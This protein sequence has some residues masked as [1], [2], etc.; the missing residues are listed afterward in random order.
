MRS[1]VLWAA[2]LLCA[3]GASVAGQDE[4]P[5][6]IR[7][8]AFVKTNRT[9]FE[10]FG[11]D[12]GTLDALG[13]IKWKTEEWNALFAVYAGKDAKNP[14]V[15]GEY[16]VADGGLLFEPRQPLQGG[17]R[18]RAEFDPAKLPD[19]RG[20]GKERI[21]R[22]FEIPSPVGVSASG[23]GGA[24]IGGPTAVR[25][26]YP[27]RDTLPE[28]QLKFYI[29]FT[30]PMGR[31]SA[32]KHVRLL[33]AKDKEI[34][35]PFLE[36]GEE[37]WDEQ[38][39][40]FT[41]FFDPGRIKRG[42]KPREEVGPALEEGKSY[43]LAIDKAWTDA[44]GRP[45]KD[46]FRKSFKV[47]PPDDTPIDPKAWKLQTPATGTRDLLTVTFPEPLDHAMLQRVLTVSDP[48]GNRLPGIIRVGKEETV[49]Q[50]TPRPVW[51]PG[52]H[53]LLVESTLEDLAGNSVG[54]PFEV[55]VFK[56]IQKET[57]PKVVRLPFTVAEK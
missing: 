2:A 6:V 33:D 15:A 17:L 45:L 42:L 51:E 14:P 30:A 24:G 56:P 55:D 38:H 23:G 8:R 54:K 9:A 34:E 4:K 39:L 1:K 36:L 20:K 31:G 44:A 11:L 21:T 16:R 57:R 25:A 12:R 47:G 49:W 5:V 7:M 46:S 28:N 53:H 52:E 26:V 3:L 43:T 27:S 19:N 13:K 40:R 41:L 22:E 18:Y 35:L 32:Y 37:L 29:H 48:Q 10:V 50:F